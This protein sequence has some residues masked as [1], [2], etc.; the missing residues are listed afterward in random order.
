[1]AYF[2]GRDVDIA[3]T[4]EHATQGVVVKEWSNITDRLIAGVQDF[5]QGASTEAYVIG[6]KGN[7]FAGPK[8]MSTALGCDENEAFG[9]LG[10]DG[11]T[12]V[13]LAWNNQPNNVTGLDVSL[14]V[15][16]EDV[17][18]IGQR[19]ILKAEIKKE[20]SLTLTRKKADNVWDGV[21][22]DARF[23]VKE[24]NTV[25]SPTTSDETPGLFTGLSAPD[26][27]GCGYRVVVRFAETV[28]VDSGSTVDDAGGNF[29]QGDGT[30]TAG[31]NSIGNND[32]IK[33]GQEILKVTS[34][35]GTTT[36]T[37]SRG[38][39]GTQDVTHNNG[40]TIYDLG[41]GGAGEVL[42]FRNCYITDHSVSLAVDG[43]Q[44]ESMTLMSYVD[45]KIY[46]GMTTGQWDDATASTEL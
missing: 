16:D 6:D 9:D 34:G 43:T 11:S 13:N 23:G 44:E 18:F 8:A 28:P 5:A 41:P 33:I 21:Y 10:G 30:L 35:G 39:F 24:S 27:V 22:N 12:L 36:L 3:I 17:A 40:T 45:P 32:Y 26:F 2:L 4:T 38:Q 42:V 25:A 37:V 7:V 19:N 20:N 46:D 14:G 1:M 31:A 15:Q 29:G